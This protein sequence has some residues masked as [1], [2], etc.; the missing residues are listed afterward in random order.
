MRATSP[1]SRVRQAVA[2]GID[3]QALLDVVLQ[4]KGDHR[5]RPP[6]RPR[7]RVLRSPASRSASATSRQAKA[8][9]EEAGKEGL[10]VTLHAPQLVRRS[11]SS[12]S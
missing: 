7:L 8:L 2:L 4:G 9:L 11:R 3:R 5:Q 1:T 6:D 10:A 12:P